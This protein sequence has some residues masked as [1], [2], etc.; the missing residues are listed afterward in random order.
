MSDTP[1]SIVADKILAKVKS[2]EL[3]SEE[4]SD[5]FLTKLKDGDI[6]AEDWKLYAE[7][8]I[9]EPEATDA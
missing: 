2:E 7:L 5:D 3:I 1:D 6:S 9:E 8:G 4:K